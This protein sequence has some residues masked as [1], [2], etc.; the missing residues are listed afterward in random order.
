M[1]VYMDPLGK[2]QSAH[3]VEDILVYA[4]MCEMY[5]PRP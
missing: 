1:V 4:P 3:V 5:Q 2:N